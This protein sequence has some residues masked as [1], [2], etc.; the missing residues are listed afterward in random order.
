M[1]IQNKNLS[2]M[3]NFFKS[4][5]KDKT[6]NYSLREVIIAICML[7]IIF[8]WI[9]QLIFNVA[10]PEF[11]FYSVVSLIGTGCFGYSIEKKQNSNN[12]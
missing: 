12:N 9:A 3:L 1:L 6:D 8:S 11:M 7:L 2:A 4:L 5:L 10:T